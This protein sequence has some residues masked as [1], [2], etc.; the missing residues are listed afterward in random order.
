MILRCTLA[1]V[2]LCAVSGFAHAETWMVKTSTLACRDRAL[3]EAFDDAQAPDVPDGCVML[4]AGERLLELPGMAG[5]FDTYVKLQRHDRSV[6]YV[7]SSSV[8]PDP[9]IGSVYD[10]R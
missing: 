1:A 3:L 2:A 6:V 4:D 8:V 7:R 9:G 10:E 5:G